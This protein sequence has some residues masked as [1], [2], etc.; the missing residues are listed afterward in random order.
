MTATNR[1]RFWLV[2]G[3]SSMGLMVYLA[4]RLGGADRTVFLPGETSAGHYQVELACEACHSRS[5]ADADAMQAA[6]EACHL[7]P[8]DDARDSHPKG[9]FTDPRNADRVAK[10]DAR[11]C[12]TCH[13]EHKPEVTLAMGVTLPEDFCV[14]CHADVGTERPSHLDMAF[15]TCAAAGCHNFHDNRAL[16]EDFLLRHVDEPSILSEAR[17]AGRNFAAVARLLPTYPRDE[18]PLSSLARSDQDG[19]PHDPFDAALLDEWSGTA[20]AASGVNCT[21]CH[22]D[23]DN[24]NWRDAPGYDRCGDCHRDESAA[25]SKGRHGMRLDAASLGRSLPPLRVAAARLPMKPAVV[26]REL[27]CGSCH[28]PHRFDTAYAV[29][30]ACLDC[31]DDQHSRAY[32]SSPHGGLWTGELSG[33]L[34][35]GSAV[36]CASCHMPRI[37]KSYDYGAYVHQLVQ[38]NQS[39][40]LRPVEKMLRPVCL[41]CHGYEFSIDA[42]ADPALISNNFTGSPAIEVQSQRL[43]VERRLE[44]ERTRDAERKA[45][46]QRTETSPSPATQ[47]D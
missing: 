10:L 33:D 1:R 23:P 16:Y 20:H 41:E 42:L 8:L 15:S 38:H 2:W 7:E 46:E 30:E 3:L 32:P 26:E 40:T 4:D 44:I 19:P 37:A 39:E 47:G 12:V 14:L 5:F 22:A 31:H 9:K 6:C 11:Y 28:G 17:L 25:F 13:I 34:Q 24:G 18:Y 21:A 43:A 27:N 29:V 36:T 35:V 45:R